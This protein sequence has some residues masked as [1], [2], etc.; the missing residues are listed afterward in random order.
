MGTIVYVTNLYVKNM[1][2][3]WNDIIDLDDLP[4]CEILKKIKIILLYRMTCSLVRKLNFFQD[5]LI[6]HQ[7]SLI[8]PDDI[9]SHYA[10]R[11]SYYTRWSTLLWKIYNLFQDG[12]IVLNDQPIS[13][14][15]KDFLRWFEIPTWKRL[16]AR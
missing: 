3:S 4:V 11:L 8:A 12:F 5:N 16:V 13:E 1:N 14:K 9:W 15:I 2:I 10:S 7:D 6:V